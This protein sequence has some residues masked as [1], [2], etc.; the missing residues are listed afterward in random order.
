[1]KAAHA[2]R[3]AQW[4][5]GNRKWLSSAERGT[6]NDCTVKAAADLM[7]KVPQSA[8]RELMI[9]ANI[10]TKRLSAKKSKELALMGEIEKL[11][12]E[13]ME[14]RRTLAKVEACDY[15]PS[16]VKE[17]VFAGLKNEVRSAIFSK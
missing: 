11:T 5:E 9:D 1:M 6:L 16:D 2:A 4:I 14:L 8:L 15:I 7:F 3:L 12:A 17:M 13:N 10:D